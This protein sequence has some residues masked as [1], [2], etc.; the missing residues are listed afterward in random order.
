[1]IQL[2]VIQL[3]V[4]Q[5]YP[6]LSQ[7]TIMIRLDVNSNITLKLYPV[8]SP[9]FFL[10]KSL[11]FLSHLL[12]PIELRVIGVISFIYYSLQIQFPLSIYLS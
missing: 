11:V 6:V 4:I 7:N 3:D 2:D 5:Y 1:M 9:R 12:Y 10:V 8:V